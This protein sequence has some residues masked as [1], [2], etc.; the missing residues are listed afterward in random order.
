M[1]GSIHLNQ[2]L[3]SEEG[4]MGSGKLQ[5]KLADSPIKFNIVTQYEQP[6]TKTLAA[7]VSQRAFPKSIIYGAA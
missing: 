3:T 6:G 7:V 1:Q 2:A 4:K 5:R